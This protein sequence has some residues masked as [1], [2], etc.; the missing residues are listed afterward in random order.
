MKAPA[1][2]RAIRT[3]ES[4]SLSLICFQK[5]SAD[6]A[7]LGCC[8]S[9]VSMIKHIAVR[10]VPWKLRDPPS[11]YKQFTAGEAERADHAW[12]NIM[13]RN[14]RIYPSEEH[15]LR[16]GDFASRSKTIEAGPPTAP[17][18]RSV[19]VAVA[20][21]KNAKSFSKNQLGRNGARIGANEQ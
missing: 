20:N 13:Q 8:A 17:C 7:H 1:L 9:E 15:Q 2:T 3:S 10:R 12:T 21:T 18:R 6:G 16:R 14:G 5:G 4:A 11:S 19:G